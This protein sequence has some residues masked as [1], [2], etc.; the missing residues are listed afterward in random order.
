MSNRILRQFVASATLALVTSCA[1]QAEQPTDFNEVG[2]QVSIL[3]QNT[4]FSR[5]KWDGKLGEKFLD[6]YL[7]DLDPKRM[8]F[9][10]PD[11]DRFHKEYSESLHEMLLRKT[12]ITAAE[13][14][15]KVFQERVTESSE[16][17][18]KNARR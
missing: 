2:K 15:Y 13:D 1:A 9:R 12:S 10:Q 18:K 6:T 3:L 4:H 14:I 8:Y 17:I 16:F 7:R 11:V 5:A